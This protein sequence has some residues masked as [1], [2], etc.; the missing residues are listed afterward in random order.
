LVPQLG[1]L[2][3]T[4]L[5]PPTKN[6]LTVKGFGFQREQYIAKLKSIMGYIVLKF[7]IVRFL[8]HSE[9]YMAT[10]YVID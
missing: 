6:G 7:D 1:E 3:W 2:D 10:Y 9:P 5:P 8:R 4:I